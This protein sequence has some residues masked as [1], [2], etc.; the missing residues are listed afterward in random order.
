MISKSSSGSL[1]SLFGWGLA[2]A[3]LVLFCGA[4]VALLIPVKYEGAGVTQPLPK[5]AILSREELDARTA[6][7]EANLRQAKESYRSRG[8]ALSLADNMK[9]PVMLLGFVTVISVLYRSRHSSIARRTMVS[10]P[11]VLLMLS[12][13]LID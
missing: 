12:L 11:T 5:G 10:M 6:Q 8:F 4:V 9:V 7:A 2:C 1:F 13:L 3:A